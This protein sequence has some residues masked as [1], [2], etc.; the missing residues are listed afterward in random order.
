VDGSV[1]NFLHTVTPTEMCNT[2]PVS[3]TFF[4][5]ENV[6]SSSSLKIQHASL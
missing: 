5:N 2:A 4:L 3:K 6:R 1:I